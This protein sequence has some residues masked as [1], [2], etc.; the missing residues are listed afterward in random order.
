MRPGV[1]SQLRELHRDGAGVIVHALD[2][3]ANLIGGKALGSRLAENGMKR[4]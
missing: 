1:I 3:L 2:L 4:F